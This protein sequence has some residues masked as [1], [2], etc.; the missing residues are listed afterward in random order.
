MLGLRYLEGI[1]E[2]G[3]VPHEPNKGVVEQW[4]GRGENDTYVGGLGSW[5]YV[6]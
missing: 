2:T 6:S 5:S 1:S 4:P 3:G